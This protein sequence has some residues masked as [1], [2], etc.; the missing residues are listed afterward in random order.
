MDADGFC[1]AGIKIPFT[2]KGHFD[3]AFGDEAAL[4]QALYQYG[5]IAIAIDAAGSPAFYY[6]QGGIINYSNCGSSRD[7]LDHEVTLIGW[8]VENGVKYWLVKNSWDTTW[9]PIFSID[10]FPSDGRS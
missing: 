3:V 9:Y 10:L 2:L 4:Q 8:G 1:N 6:Y 7:D 5:P